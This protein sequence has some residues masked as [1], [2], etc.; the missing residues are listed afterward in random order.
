[1]AWQRHA[2]KC[3]TYSLLE[4]RFWQRCERYTFPLIRFL[5]RQLSSLSQTSIN[6]NDTQIIDTNTT[7][8]TP[9]WRQL[10]VTQR[11]NLP[12]VTLVSL[13]SILTGID[14]F[15]HTQQR[16]RNT[17]KKGE[18]STP[19]TLFLVSTSDCIPWCCYACWTTREEERRSERW[20]ETREMLRFR[21]KWT[22]KMPLRSRF[23]RRNG[24]ERWGRKKTDCTRRSQS[25]QIHHLSLHWLQIQDWPRLSFGRQVCQRLLCGF[26]VDRYAFTMG[27]YFTVGHTH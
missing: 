9:K 11:L 4:L 14:S 2:L 19:L 16:P 25:S 12:E 6:F 26:A 23:S 10:K 24:Q 8:P 13:P 7:R 1:M 3:V 22:D 17:Y 15:N 21:A 18:V 5:S 27:M 20:D